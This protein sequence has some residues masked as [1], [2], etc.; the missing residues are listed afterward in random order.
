MR[1]HAID[2]GGASLKVFDEGAGTPVVLLHSLTFHSGIWQAQA[3]ALARDHRVVR[4]DLRGH[5]GTAWPEPDDVTL[6]DMADDVLAV[7]DAL[8]LPAAVVGGLSLGG[9]VALR[10]ALRRPERVRGLALLSTS[11]QVEAP[12]LR[13]FYHRVNVGSRG[14]PSDEPTVAL[15][16][17]LMF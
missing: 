9:M 6:E 8:D 3:G 16:L 10:V 13:D 17:S 1:T 11:G 7:M 15:I 14:K 12:A 4:I 5:G 2:V